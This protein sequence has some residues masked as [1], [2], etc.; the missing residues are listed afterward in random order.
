MKTN[1][2]LIAVSILSLSSCS[3]FTTQGKTVS[4]ANATIE[5]AT[6][7]DLEVKKTEIDYTDKI[8]GE[9]QIISVDGKLI[10]ADEMPY[11]NFEKSTQCFYAF[12]G[13]NVIN[14]NYQIL[15]DNK[16]ALLNV[17]ATM[18][19]CPDIEYS[20]QITANLSGAE[21]LS[22]KIDKVG[23]ESYLRFF[24]ANNREIMSARKH[25]MDFLSGNWKILSVYGNNIDSDDASLFIDIH[26]LKI[27]GNTGCNYFNGQIFLPTDKSNAVDFNNIKSTRMSCPNMQQESEIMLALEETAAA[28]SDNDNRVIMLNADGKELI[29]LQEIEMQ[30]Q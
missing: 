28:I 14:G 24:K 23:H 21:Q 18:K 5:L 11:I 7:E 17:L 27:H 15:S 12:D 16:L 10:V 6:K 20:S 26:E 3:V 8:T 25:N 4:G 19:Y 29:K 9:W 22:F 30:K 1:I 13:C 2:L